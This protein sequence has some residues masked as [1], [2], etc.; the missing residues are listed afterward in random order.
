[1]SVQKL[2]DMASNMQMHRAGD[3]IPVLDHGYVQFIE[4]WG[5]DERIIE[6]ARM[7]TGKGFRSWY[8]YYECT[9]PGCE[10]W[11]FE[12]ADMTCGHQVDFKP[13]LAK[14]G[15]EGLL[16]FL[17]DKQHTTPF[18]MA[19][20]QIETQA[21]IVVF[22]EWHRHRTQCL[23]G[24]AEV[25]FNRPVDGRPHHITMKELA[26]KWNPPRAKRRRKDQ[27][28]L[29]LL[30]FRRQ[31]IG[32]MRIRVHSG[33]T[34]PGASNITDVMI[35]GVKKLYRI[36]S[37]ERTIEA[38]ADHLFETP[39]GWFPI[40][41]LAGKE[42][43]QSSTG[44]VQVQDTWPQ[45][46]AKELAEERW[47]E[48][49]DGQEV[50]DLGR[51]RTWWGQGSSRKRSCPI[52]R[53]PS[54]NSAGRVV[55]AVREQVFQASRLVW[56]AFVGRTELDILHKDDNALDNRLRNLYAGTQMD[57][58]RDRVKNGGQQRLRIL[59]RKVDKIVA[60]GEG[61]TFDISVAHP[62]HNFIANGF[63]T[64][65][66]Y[67]EASARYAPLPAVDY[68]PS[69]ERMMRNA[70]KN[71]QA[72]AVAGADE[73]TSD[74]AEM[75]LRNLRQVYKYAEDVYQ[76]GLAAGVPK[77]L[78]RLSMTVGRYSKMRAQALLLNWLKFLRLRYSG[79]AQFEIMKYAEVIKQLLEQKFPRT[80]KLVNL[81]PVS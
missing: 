33:D 69:I 14:V 58:A 23:A 80:M 12:D 38:S 16:R 62:L 74:M 27:S 32:K 54:V 34:V 81:P 41:D 31:M 17:W 6:S 36:H 53:T 68:I 47:K 45:F 21:P 48:F 61:E 3:K 56:E 18:E 52:L 67:N 66:S 59:P 10:A 72:Q 1:M 55:V 37:G 42:V 7:S 35:S 20:M 9:C 5:S 79:D 60:C 24:S 39:D 51:V 71:K 63:V 57:N 30:E 78:A 13:R 8:P 75:W 26:R 64:H 19:G 28:P 15:D 29:S 73:L 11:W 44:G 22:R 70:G 65:N 4:G 43:Y 77:E 46:S 2:L 49:A 25:W 76:M 50:S 40:A